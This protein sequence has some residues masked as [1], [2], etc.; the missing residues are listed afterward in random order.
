MC[1]GVGLR[2]CC[3]FVVPAA[4]MYRPTTWSILISWV[5]IIP[6]QIGGQYTIIVKVTVYSDLV[7]RDCQF[8]VGKDGSQNWGLFAHFYIPLLRSLLGLK[9]LIMHKYGSYICTLHE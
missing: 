9:E 7:R 3:V 2:V 4:A 1:F 8:G 5:N 6:N